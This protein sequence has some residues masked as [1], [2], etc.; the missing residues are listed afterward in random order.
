MWPGVQPDGA[1]RVDRAYVAAVKGLVEIAAAEGLYV[2]VEPHQDELSPRWCGEGA[3]N[4]WVT[5]YTEVADFPVPVRNEPFPVDGSRPCPGLDDPCPGVDFPGRALC[6]GNS[7]FSYIWTHSAA[8]AYQALWDDAAPFA[9]FWRVVARELGGLDNVIGG[10][11]WNEPFPGDV[12]GDARLRDNGVADRENLAPFYANVTRAIRDEQPNRSAFAVAYEPS[13]PVG[14][15]D[16]NAS[17]LLP[18]TSGFEALPEPDAIYAF[19]WYV[20]PASPDLGAY[21]DARVADARRLGAAP[22]ASEWN[23]GATSEAGLARFSADLL[24]FESRGIAHTGWQYKTYQAALPGGTCTGCGSSFFYENGTAIDYTRRGCAVPFAQAVQGRF[25]EVRLTEGRYELMFA[26]SLDPNR[27]PAPTEIVVPAAFGDF[28]ITVTSGLPIGPTCVQWDV[29]EKRRD[30]A[31]LSPGVA[32][33][34]WT[35]V[36]VFI[37]GIWGFTCPGAVTIVLTAV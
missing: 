7:S 30:G 34:G 29:I 15:Q 32:Y 31:R 28:D 2:V 33:E 6:D 12:F 18:A 24:A 21:L 26:Y 1:S 27:N 22:Y 36:S 3:P 14:D 9:D 8:R 10:E 23:F 20:P 5:A 13:W 19:H 25:D 37:R 35:T 11:L 17:S 4:W 16:L